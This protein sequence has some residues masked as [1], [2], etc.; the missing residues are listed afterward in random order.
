MSDDF[1]CLNARE[2]DWKEGRA[3]Y[4]ATTVE[5]QARVKLVAP[6]YPEQR[7]LS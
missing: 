3:V 1:E 2:F 6:R 7:K 5:G 4:V